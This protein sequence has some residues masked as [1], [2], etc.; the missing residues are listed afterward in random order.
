MHRALSMLLLL[1][2]IASH[3]GTPR[4]TSA[5][6]RLFAE[7]FGRETARLRDSAL[8]DIRS[9]E[10]WG[11]QVETDRRR[12]Q[13][14]L[15]LWPAPERT[16]L[17]ATITGVVEH[18]EFR[19][20][21]LH[22]QSRPGLYVTA[23]LYLPPK[24][25]GRIPA[26]LYVCGHGNVKKDG[27]SYG[28][29][30][31]YQH[32][33]AWFARNG[34]AC[35]VIDTLQ[36]GEIEGLHHGTYREGMWWWISRGYTPGGVEAWNGIRALDYLQSR[37][38]VDPERLGITGRSGGGA[39]SW[40]VAALDPRVKAAV[41]VAGI[42]DLENHVI[43][44]TVEGHCDCMF[45]A[46][47]YQW[48]YSRLAALVAPRPLLIANTDKDTIFPLEGVVRVHAQV[49]RIYQLLKAP[50]RL[51]LLITE[52]PHRDTQDLQVPALRWFNRFLK[53]DAESQVANQAARLLQPEQL[54]V[55]D[56]LPAD[57]INTRIQE[58]FVARAKAP[59]PPADATAWAGLKSRWMQALREEVFPCW[60]QGSAPPATKTL[61]SSTHDGLRLA[62]HEMESQAG[63]QL[64][65]YTLRRERLDRPEISVVNVMD[66]PGW[67]KW[68]AQM[69]SA[70]AE[71]LAQDRKAA[72]VTGTAP[73]ELASTAAM[74]KRF[75]WRMVYVLPRGIGP[76]AW[77]PG[78]RQQTQVR[79]RFM[80]LGQSLEAMQTWDIRR[81]VQSLRSLGPAGKVWL[82]GEKDLA[83]LCVY[84]ALF[85]PEVDRLDLWQPPASHDAGPA[86]PNVLKHLDLP[87][88]AAM[89]AEKT[90]L[91][92]YNADPKAWSLVTETASRL[93]WGADR[94]QFRTT[95]GA[96]R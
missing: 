44:G 31:S 6:D 61:W 79:R 57:Q 68:L 8:A 26:V 25:E 62:A 43:D 29:K 46:N 40:Y 27:I 52:G 93:G 49:R 45:I 18:P 83:A 81:A 88:A 9:A 19:V 82:Q 85:E 64:R 78:S 60:P 65:Y 67:L 91:R 13:E 21:K 22:F 12:L 89:A 1:A 73:A 96:G 34:Y 30:A 70:F 59:A 32:H 38:E 84:A 63:V 94:V 28:S 77:N 24:P 5:G 56:R 2:A 54:R 47:R 69:G 42:T 11:R 7:Y 50:D 48:D 53:G 90:R 36:L 17:R 76:T 15:G 55:F 72:G 66:D 58:T 51:G 75:P 37:P 14:M 10:D 92:F 16:P 3:G 80:L 33:G 74:L 71:P 39:Y 4:D 20:E 86:L 23:S 95:D 41:P 87:A 35:M